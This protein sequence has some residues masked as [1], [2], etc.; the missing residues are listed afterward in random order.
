MTKPIT[1][2]AQCL[3]FGLQG[4]AEQVT[5]FYDGVS[6]LL[7]VAVYILRHSL[8]SS[9]FW[10]EFNRIKMRCLETMVS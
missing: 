8:H 3:L 10:R 5:G 4:F 7:A 6:L 2:S 9:N 1:F